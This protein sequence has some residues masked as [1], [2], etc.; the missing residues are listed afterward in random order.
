ES[1]LALGMAYAWRGELDKAAPEFDRAEALAPNNADVLLLISWYLPPMGQTE[2]ALHLADR[3]TRLNPN[4]PDWYTPGLR[5][6]YF[7]GRQFEKSLK[8]A[9]SV[10]QRELGDYVYLALINVNLG[11]YS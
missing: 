5:Y 9:K 10:K 2:R 1:H 6:V 4:Y 7:F 11:H 8:A 3:A